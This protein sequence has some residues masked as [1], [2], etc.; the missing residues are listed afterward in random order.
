MGRKLQQFAPLFL[1]PMFEGDSPT[2]AQRYKDNV[3]YKM[4][5]TEFLL[6]FSKD[7]T[8]QYEMIEYDTESNYLCKIKN[9]AMENYIKQNDVSREYPFS[10]STVHRWR[11]DGTLTTYRQGKRRVLLS[12]D[13]LNALLVSKEKVA[14]GS[15]DEENRSRNVNPKSEGKDSHFSS[16]LQNITFKNNKSKKDED[17]RP[18]K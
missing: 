17:L 8:V 12:R 2:K 7:N 4:A 5:K 15:G 16:G 18:E 14:I 1:T 10:L 3:V 9:Q 6:H 11:R 13:E